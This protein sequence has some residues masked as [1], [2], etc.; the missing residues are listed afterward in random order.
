MKAVRAAQSPKPAR[1]QQPEFARA[2]VRFHT[3]IPL[4]TWKDDCEDPQSWIDEF[5]HF[6]FLQS[7]GALDT[8]VAL[9]SPH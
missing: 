6:A 4:A 5:K 7:G 3:D 9:L 1:S 2:G 8:K